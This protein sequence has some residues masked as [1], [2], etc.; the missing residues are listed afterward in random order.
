MWR[1]EEMQVGFWSR[2]LEGEK[3][4]GRSVC[5]WEDDIVMDRKEI[6]WDSVG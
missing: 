2:K 4:L 5:R 1:G 3:L 6:G